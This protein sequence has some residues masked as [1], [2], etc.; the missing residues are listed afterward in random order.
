[1][2][3]FDFDMRCGN[4]DSELHRIARKCKLEHS[5]EHYADLER[6]WLGSVSDRQLQYDGKYLRVPLQ[7]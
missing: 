5:F 7:V 6:N 4:S 1:M 3:L 2:E